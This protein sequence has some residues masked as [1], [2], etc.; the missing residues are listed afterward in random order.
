MTIPLLSANLL[1]NYLPNST[2]RS[3]LI[4]ATMNIPFFY[5]GIFIWFKTVLN[6]Q[7][8]GMTGMHL[9]IKGIIVPMLFGFFWSVCSLLIST[10][11]K[12][13]L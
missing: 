10:T 1:N 12:P 5:W 4:I 6:Y 3:A 2:L 13:V 9:Y 11:L 7:K 8:R